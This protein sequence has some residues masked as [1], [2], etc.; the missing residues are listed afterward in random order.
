MTHE[1]TQLWAFVCVEDDG[2]EGVIAF[3]TVDGVVLPL[4]GSDLDRVRALRS[5]A[6]Q[7]VDATGQ[8]VVLKRFTAMEVV[9]TFVPF[10]ERQ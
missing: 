1:I 6:R 5:L 2:D 7:T 9:E 4:I 8:P 10:G 3:T